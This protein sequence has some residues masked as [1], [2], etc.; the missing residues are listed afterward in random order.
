MDAGSAAVYWVT[1]DLSRGEIY[2][3]FV[4][5]WGQR[6]DQQEVGGRGGEIELTLVLDQKWE[7]EEEGEEWL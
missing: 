3:L 5:R 7:E 6:E 4:Q 2:T 1:A